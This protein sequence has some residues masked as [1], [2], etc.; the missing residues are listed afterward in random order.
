MLYYGLWTL[1][2]RFASHPA[3]YFSSETSVLSDVRRNLSR[4][5]L[6]FD[7]LKNVHMNVLCN[8]KALLLRFSIISTSLKVNKLK[9]TDSTAIKCYNHNMFFGLFLPHKSFKHTNHAQPSF[10]QGSKSISWIMFH[11]TKHLFY[12]Q[13]ESLC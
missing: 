1:G 9:V 5:H 8:Q 7:V 11:Q 3:G 2:R 10:K 4:Q 12:F 6:W 13:M